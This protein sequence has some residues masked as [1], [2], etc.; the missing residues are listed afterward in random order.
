MLPVLFWYLKVCRAVLIAIHSEFCYSIFIKNHVYRKQHRKDKMMYLIA[1]LGNPTREYDKTRHNVGFSV[2]D[3]LADKYNID[4]SDRKHKAL[5]GRG[6]I[7]GEKVLLLKPQTFMNLSGESIREAVDY[8]KIDPE[9]IIVIYDD[10][11]LEP[12]QLRIRLKGSAGGHNGIKNIIAHLGTQEFPRIKVGV[13][14][15]PPKM[16]LADYVLSRF[17]AEEQKIMDEAFGEAAEAAVMMMT[18]GAER[19]MNHYNAKKKAE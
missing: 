9:D 18:T 11:S 10:I 7:E 17:G 3:V 13:G 1:G 8:Y 14:A 16:D 6:V 19:V 5:C 15:K 12:G 2:I 4:V